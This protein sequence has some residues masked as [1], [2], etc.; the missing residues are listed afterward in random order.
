MKNKKTTFF[1]SIIILT[2][3]LN[4][5]LKSQSISPYLF[6][7]NAWMPQYI[8][9]TYYNGQL[10]SHW[11]DINDSHCKS[12]R[13]GGTAYDVHNPTGYYT[14]LC[15]L[16]NS[17]QLNGGEPIVQVSNDNGTYTASQA[18]AIVYAINTT[19][20]TSIKRK[21]KYWVIANEPDGQY[22]GSLKQASGIATYIKA[23]SIAMKGVTGQSDIKIIAPELSYYNSKGGNTY[24]ILTDATNGLLNSSS[25]NDITGY[26][27][28]GGYYYVDY[29]SFHYYPFGPA[30]YNQTPAS[31]TN[32]LTELSRTYGFNWQ[33]GDLSTKVSA[34][35]TAHSRTGSNLLQTAITEGNINTVN[36]PDGYLNGVSTNSFIA[37]Q[38][39][40]EM[41]AYCMQNSVQ[42]MNFW[43]VIE[44]NDLGYL[45]NAD[46]SKRSTYYHFQMVANNFKGTFSAG[47]LGGTGTLK[48]FGSYNSDQIA[49][50]VMNQNTTSSLSYSI[51]F[52]TGTVGGTGSVKINIPGPGL[53]S[54]I[55]YNGNINN[56]TSTLLLFDPHGNLSQQINYGLSDSLSAP[57]IYTSCTAAGKIYATQGQLDAYTPGVYST[58][59]IGGTSSIT[60]SATNNSV[61]KAIGDIIINGEFIV[62]DGLGLSLELLPGSACQ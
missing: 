51:M 40:A 57:A 55:I 16:I 20:I 60:L 21:V 58:I 45:R 13:I 24:E 39:W 11:Q 28:T 38:F 1:C 18:A 62:P 48:A 52:N 4:F 36:P 34:A 35:N 6:G 33:L 15:S 53:S 22:S 32:V 19:Y 23:F 2:I 56:Q 29:I 5:Q 42:F 59:T 25:S 41:M 12:V 43:S 49:V 31:P 37:G 27:S 61:Y 47:T 26:Y 44:G 46:A 54:S 30:A 9:A 17:I 7:Q 8:D 14:Q 10:D 3:F 50:L